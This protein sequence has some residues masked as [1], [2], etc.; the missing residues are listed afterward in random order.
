MLII[1]LVDISALYIV[2]SLPYD[3]TLTFQGDVHNVLSLC[4]GEFC[5]VYVLQM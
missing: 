4:V 3:E 5:F 2:T 1:I